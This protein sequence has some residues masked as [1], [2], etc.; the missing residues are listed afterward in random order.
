MMP[1]G[2]AEPLAAMVLSYVDDDEVGLLPDDP[3]T[4]ARRNTWWYSIRAGFVDVPES[5]VVTAYQTANG[6]MNLFIPTSAV[7][8]RVPSGCV[9]RYSMTLDGIVPGRGR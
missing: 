4:E 5:L 2:S 9:F 1:D 7:V 8:M 6:L 3:V